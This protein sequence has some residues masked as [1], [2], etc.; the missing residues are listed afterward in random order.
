MML[1]ENDVVKPV[2]FDV[3]NETKPCFELGSPAEIY[4]GLF[5]QYKSRVM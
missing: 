4:H 1:R 3:M 2:E 5:E